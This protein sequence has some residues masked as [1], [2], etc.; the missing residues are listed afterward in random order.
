MRED[1]PF[2]FLQNPGYGRKYYSGKVL[3]DISQYYNVY[4]DIGMGIAFS[5][6]LDKIL[7]FLYQI[8]LKW[9]K[10]LGGAA[11]GRLIFDI[12]SYMFPIIFGGLFCSI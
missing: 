9:I 4:F 7:S 2:L 3:G 12:E 8:A 11:G 10:S 6:L 5:K 1:S